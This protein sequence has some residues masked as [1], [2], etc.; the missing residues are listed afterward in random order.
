MP[1][2]TIILTVD[3]GKYTQTVTLTPY[4]WEVSDV[5][6]DAL[7]CRFDHEN[8]L[9]LTEIPEASYQLVISALEAIRWEV[10]GADLYTIKQAI[11]IVEKLR[12]MQKMREWKR[13]KE[14][15]EA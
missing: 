4:D 9:G 6:F 1:N 11:G 8:E 12:D 2:K 10:F 7:F 3:E 5:V 15:S 14:E 13:K